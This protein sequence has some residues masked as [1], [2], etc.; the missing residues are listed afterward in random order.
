MELQKM[1]VFNRAP[2][3]NLVLDFDNRN[4]TVLSGINGAGKTTLISYIVDSLYELAKKAFHNEFEQY[5]NAYYRIMSGL[6]IL[7]STKPSIVYLRYEHNGDFIDYIDS[8]GK[9]SEEQYNSIIS[10][11]SP[12]NDKRILSKLVK[13]ESFKEWSI[14]DKEP[15]VNLFDSNL[16]TF[17]PAY[18]Y[19]APFYLN[20]HYGMSLDFRVQGFFEG[21][22]KNKIEID[23]DL[24]Q[25]ANWIMD[26]VMDSRQYA[27]V[28]TEMYNQLCTILTQIL[29]P[30]THC[31]IRL[32][33]GM[34]NSGAARIAIINADN[35]NQLY[36]SIFSMSSGELALLCLFGE[37]LKQTDILG[38]NTDKINGIVIVDEIDKHL[39]ITL[40]R[41]TLP[42][43]VKIFPNIQFIVTSHSPFF[44]LGLEE[45]GILYSII[46][47][48]NGGICCLPQNNELFKE[49]YDL[50]I[51]QNQQYAKK[52]NDLVTEVQKNSK[53]IIITEGK[54]DWK[55]L[56]AAMKALNLNDLDVDYHEYTDTIGDT[57]LYDMLKDLSRI[58]RTR[59]I[60][61]V[62]DRDNPVILKNIVADTKMYYD[63][64]N[65]VYAFAIPLVHQDIYGDFISIEQ[66]YNKDD[67]CKEDTN[68]RRLFL[69]SEFFYRGNSKDGKYQTCCKNIKH[70]VEING[71][72]DE[73]VY[74]RANDLE[75]KTSIALSK[76]A[77]AQYVLEED[78]FAEGFDFSAFS[79]I[80]DVMCHII[81]PEQ[82]NQP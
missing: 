14:K 26:V 59:K 57:N 70:K 51:D 47:L 31:R 65:N 81:N 66:Y 48:D 15:I 77:F 43:L 13:G 68:G 23:T 21:N 11:L 18:R 41:D 78:E 10:L 67:L 60:I 37:L 8:M 6:N 1:I 54:T 49:V 7:D 28:S 34:R 53:P 35:N 44:N 72:I 2:F 50:M 5:P 4:V 20:N 24:P 38:F 12:M 63:F 79:R 22:L 69:G 74:D 32:G 52:Y 16:L 36:P 80:F 27:G 17:F 61:G 71:I 40:Q 33:I 45:E 39:H 55:H 19:E 9:C 75:L 73:K 29:I 3:E 64:G 82:G 56:K 25:I 62:F 58:P 76:D 30:K 46:D 42:K